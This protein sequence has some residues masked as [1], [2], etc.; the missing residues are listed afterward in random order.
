MKKVWVNLK[1]LA[2]IRLIMKYLRVV[3]G[4]AINYDKVLIG[5]RAS[6][7]PMPGLW[8]FPGGKVQ[9]FENDHEALIRE[10]DE[11]FGIQIQPGEL[12]CESHSMVQRI[13]LY[14]YLISVNKEPVISNSH[15]EIRWVTKEELAKLEVCNADV[16]IV[17][18]VSGLI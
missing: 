5:K 16:E 12:L 15:D 11:E 3:A 9:L 7:K 14:A 4:V 2:T 6:N 10:F 1:E 18:K 8:E 17:R 13:S